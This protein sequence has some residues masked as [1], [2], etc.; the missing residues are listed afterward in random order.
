MKGP[1]GWSPHHITSRVDGW[2]CAPADEN[3]IPAAVAEL[4]A[5]AM[6]LPDDGTI[7]AIRARMCHRHMKVLGHV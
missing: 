1:P 7:A 2:I 6:P 4:I 5:R 3:H